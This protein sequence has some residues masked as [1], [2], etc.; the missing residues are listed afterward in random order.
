MLSALVLLFGCSQTEKPQV[1][2]PKSREIFTLK[3]EKVAPVLNLTGNVEAEKQIPISA[4]IM[5]R[6]D[7]LKVDVGDKVYKGQ[8]L[9]RYSAV[10]NDSLARYQSALSQFKSTEASAENAVNTAEVQLESAE[11]ALEQTKKEEEV[12]RKKQ[13]DNLYTNAKLSE[14]TI[15]NV[16]NFLDKNLEAS[17]KFEGMS[18]YENVLGRNNSILKNDLKNRVEELVRNFAGFSKVEPKSEQAILSFATERLDFLHKVKKVLLDFDTLV[19]GTVSSRTF[20]E[21]VKNGFVAETAN[22]L[23]AISQAITNLENFITGTKVMDEQLGLKV[24]SVE[25]QLKSAKSGVELAK[26]NAENQVVAARSQVN[27]ASTYQREMV[28]K[29]PFAGVIISRDIDMGQLVSPG[30]KLFEL[31]DMSGFKIK[32]DVSDAYAAMIKVD[33]PVEISVDGLKE[34]FAGIVTKVNPALDPR[35]RKLG[36]EITFQEDEDAEESVL[37]KLKIGLFARIKIQLPERET[38]KIPRNFVRFDYEGAK[39]ELE[40]GEVKEVDILSEEKDKVEIYFDGIEEGL[41]IIN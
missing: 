33:M 15:S 23:Q 25:N 34:N 5:G 38:F 24:L 7:S 39:I 35:T 16:L 20:P 11:R 26:A 36:I 1:E 2:Q 41:K 14:I 3:A 40:N 32:T 29:A 12:Q 10:D 21:A 6:I 13:Y 18:P 4:K 22:Y 28:V 37:D 27:I 19:R 31:A 17:T 8:I 9:A 30:Q